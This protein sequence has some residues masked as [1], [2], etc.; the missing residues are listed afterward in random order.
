MSWLSIPLPNPF[1]S[2]H[3]S[4]DDHDDD[5]QQHQVEELNRNA[6]Q[7]SENDAVSLGGGV[8]ED[9]SAIG[10]SI[11]RRFRGVA[12]FLAPP[13]TA[14][15]SSSAVDGIRSDLAEIGGTFKNT[16]S[17][18][19]NPNKAVSEISKFASDFLQLNE[20][21]SENVDDGDD[22]VKNDDDNDDYDDDEEDEEEY[23]AGVTDEVIEFARQ[24]SD[25]P[26]LWIDFPLPLDHHVFDMSDVQSEHASIV[27]QLVPSFADL[28]NKISSDKSEQQFWMIYFILLLPRLN[29]DDLELLSTP[30][31]VDARET[32]LMMLRMKK[33]EENNSE[34]SH[35]YNSSTLDNKVD[36]E[37]KNISSVRDATTIENPISLSK[38]SNESDTVDKKLAGIEDASTATSTQYDPADGKAGDPKS[39]E[40]PSSEV[41]KAHENPKSFQTE[42]DVSFSDLEED[43]DHDLRNRETSSGSYQIKRNSSTEGSTDWVRLNEGTRESHVRGQSSSRE[44][45]SEGEESTDW[46]TV[47]D[48]DP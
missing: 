42:D 8:K 43:D 39:R 30:Q 47:D 3:F 9:L 32:L 46:L 13:S 20:E 10:D 24:I 15:S 36:A 22:Y 31:I 18:F 48:F 27:E 41:P 19:S 45:D 26:E 21:N 35:P 7:Q 17:L 6:P 25:R 2:L 44:R 5:D 33:D 12:A 23:G 16:L 38:D 14:E 4:D 28:K 11:S 29:D 40:V 37:A 34:N 1:K